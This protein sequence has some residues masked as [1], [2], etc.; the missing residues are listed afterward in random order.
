MVHANEKHRNHFKRKILS[1]SCTLTPFYSVKQ[2]H[3]DPVLLPFYSRSTP[4]LL[5]FYSRSTALT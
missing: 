4:V 3:P 5:P 2:L 1:S